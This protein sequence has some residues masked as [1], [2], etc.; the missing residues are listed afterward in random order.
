MLTQKKI[1]LAVDWTNILFRSLFMSATFGN[2]HYDN[3]SELQSFICKFGQDLCY[4]FK[5][6]SPDKVILMTDS[7]NAWR[8]DLLPNDDS[9]YK[10]NR[11]KNDKWD[12]DQI[13]DY[14][15]RL[16]AEMIK[17]GFDF[18][19][20]ERC[21]ADDLLCMTKELIFQKYNN[22][23]VIL[24]SSD[25]DIRQL[26]DFNPENNQYCCIYNPIS[27]KGSIRRLFVTSDFFKWY[28]SEDEKTSNDIFFMNI[29]ND[30]YRIKTI[31]NN[32][33]NKIKI[34][35]IDP[36]D[37]VLSKIFCGDSGDNV[38]SFYNWYSPKGKLSRITELKYSKIKE[39][40]ELK[41]VQDLETKISFL[42]ENIEPVIKKELN[43][44]D[45]S[46]RLQRQKLL[47]ELK[48]SNFPK[49]IQAYKADLDL[50]INKDIKII[51][52]QFNIHLLFKDTEFEN[53]LMK[54]DKAEQ[55]VFKD[56]DK[57]I[58]NNKL[59]KLW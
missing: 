47:V 4:L 26:A 56:L 41:S 36:N 27:L 13:F 24:V 44:I 16:K 8:K 6:F 45:I 18:G 23:N 59:N 48:S 52:K 3:E 46:E 37:I 40:M 54:K 2:D 20:C 9:G 7:R 57:Y 39:S 17:K 51:P 11:E 25:A 19:E 30:K 14:A 22:W 29:N 55:A 31:I 38:P 5:V 32:A 12:W 28:L 33:G 43:D 34:E 53:F 50:I 58:T 49:Y 15:N 35:I 21:E 42:K 10:A 1:L